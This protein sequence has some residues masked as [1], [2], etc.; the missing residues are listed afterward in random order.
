[1]AEV[2]DL[3]TFDRHVFDYMKAKRVSVGIGRYNE[4]RPIYTG[5]QD[6]MPGNDGPQWRTVHIGLDPFM[7]PGSPVLAPLDGILHRFRNNEA[8]LHY[9]PTLLLPHTITGEAI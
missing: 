2:A 8:P 7:Q 4:A 5:E 9:R 1:M 3:E 6:K